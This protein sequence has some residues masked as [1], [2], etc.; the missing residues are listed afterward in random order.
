M[1][2]RRQIQNQIKEAQQQSGHTNDI[3]QKLK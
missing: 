2:K 3:P 1:R